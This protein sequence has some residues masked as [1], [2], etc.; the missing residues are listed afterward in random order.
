MASRKRIESVFLNIPYNKEF[1]DLYVAYIVGLS[2]LG[3]RVN[4]TLAVP[5]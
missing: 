4:A 1:E 5:N 2:Q 3:L